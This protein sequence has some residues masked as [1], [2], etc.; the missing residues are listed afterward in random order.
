MDI[1]IYKYILLMEEI[2]N[3]EKQINETKEIHEKVKLIKERNDLIVKEKEELTYILDTN[4]DNIKI[5]IPIKYKKMNIEE[6][7]ETFNSCEN[8]NEKIKIYH[9]INKYYINILDELVK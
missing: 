9:A 8:I 2:L 3:I 6:L 1:N 5:K 4:I 7:E